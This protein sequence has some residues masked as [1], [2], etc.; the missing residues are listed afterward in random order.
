MPHR[1]VWPWHPPTPE[2]S[3]FKI[4]DE[5]MH[6]GYPPKLVGIIVQEN[7]DFIKVMWHQ[8]S[9]CWYHRSLMVIAPAHIDAPRP[10]RG[11]TLASRRA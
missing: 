9:Q 1:N 10:W 2:Q 3:A 5:V 7:G 6:K 11:N 8:R 4:G